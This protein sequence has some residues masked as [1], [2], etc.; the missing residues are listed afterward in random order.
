[1]NIN[2]QQIL[3]ALKQWLIFVVMN[4]KNYGMDSSTKDWI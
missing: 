1:M 2:Q 3:K 4:C